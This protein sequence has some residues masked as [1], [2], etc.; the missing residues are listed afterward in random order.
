MLTQA[1]VSDANLVYMLMNNGGVLSKMV[2]ILY[3]MCVI[4]F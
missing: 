1:N 4:L 2:K 3:K